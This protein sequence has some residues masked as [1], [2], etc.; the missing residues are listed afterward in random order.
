[1]IHI[2]VVDNTADQ[3]LKIDN[4]I[5]FACCINRAPV[6]EYDKGISIGGNMGQRNIMTHNII[7]CANISYI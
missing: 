1:M 3:T 2:S 7:N 5:G 4:V 6:K